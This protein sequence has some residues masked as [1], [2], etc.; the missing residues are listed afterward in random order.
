MHTVRPVHGRLYEFSIIGAGSG[1]CGS[2]HRGDRSRRPHP[3]HPY[4]DLLLDGTPEQTWQGDLPTRLKE[5]CSHW[6]VR[7]L[8]LDLSM[9]VFRDVYLAKRLVGSRHRIVESVR[10]SLG[11]I[12]SAGTPPTGPFMSTRIAPLL[13]GPYKRAVKNCVTLGKW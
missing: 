3:D 6:F 8:D 7:D 4:P 13:L 2:S 12:R 5:P 1:G 9:A 10:E 11:Y